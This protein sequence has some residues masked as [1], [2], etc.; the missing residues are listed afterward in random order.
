MWDTGCTGDSESKELPELSGG[1]Q[2]KIIID[3]KCDPADS[4]GTKWEFK[5]SC[6]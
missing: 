6:P 2:V 5:L 4:S 1:G 3:P